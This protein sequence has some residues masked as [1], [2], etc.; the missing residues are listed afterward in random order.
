MAHSLHK[1]CIYIDEAL[2]FSA[3]IFRKYKSD[4]EKAKGYYEKIVLEHPDSIYF[5]EAR[6]QYRL[7][8]GDKPEGS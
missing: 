6:M 8:R 1:D 4:Y 7:L 5:T 2:F 3:E